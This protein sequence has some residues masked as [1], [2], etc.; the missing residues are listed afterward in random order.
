[1]ASREFP[2]PPPVW[3]LGLAVWVAIGIAF[4]PSLDAVLERSALPLRIGAFVL[5]FA[6]YAAGIVAYVF[7]RPWGTIVVRLGAFLYVI[8]GIVVASTS[9]ADASIGERV[10]AP[11]VAALALGVALCVPVG[12]RFVDGSSYPGERRFGFRWPRRAAGGIVLASLVPAAAVTA[13][14]LAL[15][16]TGLW[17]WLGVALVFVTWP[18]SWLV[19]RQLG[20]LA[21]RWLVFAPQAVVAV[22]PYLL[23]EPMRIPLPRVLDCAVAPD[24]HEPGA[25]MLDL[26]A[27]AK[28]D[29]LQMVFDDALDPPAGRPLPKAIAVTLPGIPDRVTGVAWPVSAPSRALDAADIMNLPTNGEVLALQEK[30]AQRGQRRADRRTTVELDTSRVPGETD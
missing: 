22:D 14:L 12:E 11:V 4:T 5:F 20:V 2:K 9:G 15:G 18:A 21:H 10:A 7:P 28:G 27:S 24:D 1:M 25:G 8:A 13:L 29:W 3:V 16:G 19:M 6:L 17:R 23:G 30:L 26:R